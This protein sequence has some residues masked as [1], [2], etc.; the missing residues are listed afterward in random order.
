[1]KNKHH[2]IKFFREFTLIELLVT[3]G[4]MAILAAM[5]LPALGKARNYA[6]SIVCMNNLRQHNLGFSQYAM[7]N[8]EWMPLDSTAQTC[9]RHCQWRFDIAPYIGIKLEDPLFA[10][11]GT[12]S[13][14]NTLKVMGIPPIFYCPLTKIDGAVGASKAYSYGFASS[15]WANI[16]WNKGRKKLTAIRGK[17]PSETVIS[18]DTTDD[19]SIG[20]DATQVLWNPQCRSSSLTWVGNRHNK[21]VNL[22]WADGHTE[23]KSFLDLNNGK[24]GKTSYYWYIY[25]TSAIPYSSD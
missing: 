20:N 18:G 8:N 21:G 11:D 13:W 3:I 25:G 12:Y 24:N 2:F 15:D 7:D 14:K 1:M 23:W 22:N 5:L 19:T 9:Y 4:I 17:S 16:G 10:S 6:K